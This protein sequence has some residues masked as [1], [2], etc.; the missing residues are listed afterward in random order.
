MTEKF[1]N[2]VSRNNKGVNLSKMFS[3]PYTQVT[4]AETW[5]GWHTDMSLDLKF[6]PTL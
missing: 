6:A 1:H 5:P 3:V 2:I 4:W